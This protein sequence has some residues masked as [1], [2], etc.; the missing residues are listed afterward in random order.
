MSRSVTFGE[1]RVVLRR[2][3]FSLVRS[4]KHETW[5]KVEADGTIRRVT[6]R[7][8]HNKTIGRGLFLA[9]CRQ[10]GVTEAQFFRILD[11]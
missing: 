7:H 1:F 3:G 5:R 4:K 10:A 9:M 6:V 11:S 8:Q 2:L